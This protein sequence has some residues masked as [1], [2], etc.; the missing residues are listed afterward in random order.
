MK[1]PYEPPLAPEVVVRGAEGS[2]EDAA[3]EIIGFLEGRRW[4]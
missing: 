4:L 3:G 1:I 2:P